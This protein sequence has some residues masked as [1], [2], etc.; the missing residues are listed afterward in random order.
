MLDSRPVSHVVLRIASIKPALLTCRDDM[1]HLFVLLTGLERFIDLNISGFRKA[2]KKHDKVLAGA[3]D[4][5]KLKEGY[6]PV[7]QRQCCAH[8]KTI[9]EVREATGLAKPY[10]YCNLRCCWEIPCLSLAAGTC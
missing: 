10:S 2:L 7:V 6:M 9:L 3:G 4:S 1:Q 5:G 8:R